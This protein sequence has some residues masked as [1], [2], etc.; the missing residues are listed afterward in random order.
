MLMN[1]DIKGRFKFIHDLDSNTYSITLERQNIKQ[2]KKR[3]KIYNDFRWFIHIITFTLVPRNYGLDQATQSILKDLKKI[4]QLTKDDEVFLKKIFEQL[5]A[6]NSKNGGNKDRQIEKTAFKISKLQ[7]V[8]DLAKTQAGL[9]EEIVQPGQSG[10][11]NISAPID[12]ANLLEKQEDEALEKPIQNNP[13]HLEVPAPIEQKPNEELKAVVQP[14]LE[15]NKESLNDKADSQEQPQEEKSNIEVPPHIKQKVQEQSQ[16][17]KV[18]KENQEDQPFIHEEASP[19]EKKDPPRELE[20]QKKEDPPEPIIPKEE[21][22]IPLPKELKIYLD[23]PNK[24]YVADLDESL[25][26]AHLLSNYPV[27]E[28]REK[29]LKFIIPKIQNAGKEKLAPKLWEN[30]ETFI[31]LFPR[32]NKKYQ[33]FLLARAFWEAF[34]SNRDYKNLFKKASEASLDIWSRAGYIFTKSKDILVPTGQFHKNYFINYNDLARTKLLEFPPKF[35]VALLKRQIELQNKNLGPA[36]FHHYFSEDEPLERQMEFLENIEAEFFRTY[37]PPHKRD[38]ENYIDIHYLNFIKALDSC[39][40]N[41]HTRNIII[42]VINNMLNVKDLS[43]EAINDLTSKI[44]LLPLKAKNY[45]AHIVIGVKTQKIPKFDENPTLKQLFDEPRFKE[46]DGQDTIIDWLKNPEFQKIEYTEIY[47]HLLAFI[48]AHNEDIVPEELRNKCKKLQPLDIKRYSLEND[49]ISCDEFI[50]IL[51]SLEIDDRTLLIAL[52]WKKMLPWLQANE[53]NFTYF[54]QLIASINSPAKLRE[55]MIPII[56]SRKEAFFMTLFKVLEKEP[57]KAERIADKLN[58]EQIKYLQQWLQKQFNENKQLTFPKC[59]R[60]FNKQ[61]VKKLRI[62]S[63]KMISMF[64]Y[65]AKDSIDVMGKLKLF[66][67]FGKENQDEFLNVTRNLPPEELKE[68]LLLQLPPFLAIA[69]CDG[70]SRNNI[71]QAMTQGDPL[72]HPFVND[73]VII[74]QQIEKKLEGVAEPINKFLKALKMKYDFIELK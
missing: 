70:K 23:Q 19:I 14:P 54:S 33:S 72:P 8:E 59:L 48:F 43:N 30:R 38:K 34:K 46:N 67:N 73:I 31:K 29:G 49:S 68:E 36:L 5:R 18:K 55:L 45:D 27:K 24:R 62:E 44:L 26:Y 58:E 37:L 51:P 47:Y 39:K 15:E 57:W 63:V 69:L 3:S 16:E 32:L 17:E 53:E 7:V 12:R 71:L 10:N 11:K 52:N 50:R 66:S 61:N 9:Q 22:I 1:D 35:I 40:C 41:E 25:R 60:C 42:D 13:E 6:F 2:V 28:I 4:K 64:R 74:A 20:A 21:K 65:T 56:E